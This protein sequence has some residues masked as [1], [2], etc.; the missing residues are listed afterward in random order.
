MDALS[1]G[2]AFV[3]AVRGIAVTIGDA[4]NTAQDRLDTLGNKSRS[5]QR[6]MLN[7]RA[8]VTDIHTALTKLDPPKALGSAGIRI[9][10]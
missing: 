6:G 1:T 2:D 5:A 4:L 3:Q 8:S 10:V 7:A 9:L